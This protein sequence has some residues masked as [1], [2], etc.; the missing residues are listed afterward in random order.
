[1]YSVKLAVVRTRLILAASVLSMFA[2]PGL[3][4]QAVAD[5]KNNNAS[6][7]K[8]DVVVLSPFVVSGEDDNGY[9]ATSTLAGTRVRTDLRDVPSATTA[10]T[11]QFMKDIGATNQQDLL[12]YTT[13][14]EVGGVRGNF[15]GMG[16][17][18]GISEHSNLLNPSQNTRVRGL[19]TAQNTRDYFN[20]DIPWDSYIV[21][22]VDLQRGPNSVLFGIGSPAGIVNSS[23]NTAKFNDSVKIE[24]RVGSYNSLRETFDYNKVLLKNEL[25]FRVVALDDD[26]QYRQDPAFNHDKRIFGALRYEPKLF[27]DSAHTSIRANFESGTIDANRPRDLVPTDKITPYFSGEGKNNYDPYKAWNPP[28]IGASSAGW[29]AVTGATGTDNTMWN[30]WA[31]VYMAR[32]G[33]SNPVFWYDA[34]SGAP[35]YVQTSNPTATYGINSSGVVNGQIG[36]FPFARQTSIAGYNEYAINM[37]KANPNVFLGAQKNYYKDK[38]LTDPS[39][40]DFYNKLIDGPNK[41]EWQRWNAYNLALDQTFLDNKLGFEFV[42]DHQDS[43]N[44]QEGLL[45][46]DTPFIGVDINSYEMVLPSVLGNG[47]V[48][49]PNVDRAYIG[50]SNHYGNNRSHTIRDNYR[51]TAFAEIN[52]EDYLGKNFLARLLGKN[53]IT[54]LASRETTSTDTRNYV[55][56]ATDA[57]FAIDQGSTISPKISDGARQIDWIA[58]LSGNLS[59]RT[60][61]SGAGISNLSAV[62]SPQSTSVAIY[63]SHWKASL[64]PGSAGYVDPS[65]VWTDPNTGKPSTQSENPANY[66]GWTSKQVNVLS[67]ANG[68]IDQLYTDAS[69]QKKTIDSTGFTWQGSW[70]DDM[71]VPSFSWRRDKQKLQSADAPRDPVTAV[72]SMNYGITDPGTISVGDTKSYGVVLHLPKDIKKNLPAGMDVSLTYFH[73]D[74]T[75]PD[76]RYG[77]TGQ[78]L[79]PKSGKT[80]DYGIVISALDD[81]V[82]LK[83]N[84]FKTAGKNFDL[85]GDP[86]T[87]TLGANTYYLLDLQSWGTASAAIDTLGMQGKLASNG[88]EW[89]WDWA[90]IDNGWDGKYNDPKGADFLNAAS[91]AKEKAAVAAW[92]ATMPSQQFFDNYGL[93]VNVAK[94]KAG[95]TAGAVPTLIGNYS[96]GAIQPA[97]AGKINGLYPVG[98]VDTLSEGYEFEFNAR[99]TKNWN[100]TFNA[101]KTNAY[102]SNLGAELSTFIVQ[103]QTRFAGPAGDLRLWWGGDNTIRQYWVQ[104]IWAAYQFQLESDGAAAPELRPWHFNLVTNYNFDRGLLKGTNVG[105]GYRWDSKLVLGYGLTNTLTNGVITDTFMDVNKPIYGT[106]ERHFDLWTGYGHKLSRKINWRAQLNLRNVGEKA[107]LVPV[108]AEPDG[109]PAAQRISEGMTWQLSNTFEF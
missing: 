35:Q 99:P 109:S 28:P 80:D 76:I 62:L 26:A 103:Q 89:Y 64:T 108:S 84:K 57:Q 73:G 65:A 100:L 29:G 101:S 97:G 68:N 51:F 90:L 6:T 106:P 40:F 37:N 46:G 2:G 102:R 21:G 17:Q 71:I 72:A 38:S 91:T 12:V 104:N 63:D 61:A 9:Q 34:N 66:I 22:R 88:L 7:D 16:N 50:G 43:S 83:I 75:S 74:N 41:K 87:S 55:L 86:S 47:A 32:L 78:S 19:D 45:N 30:P 15:G 79:A 44:G 39:I 10:I 92:I 98:T 31:S 1:M 11:A 54:G 82:S 27:S 93:P 23:I 14:T 48:A 33:S 18:N 85:S 53:T 5:A 69:K 60:S 25:S 77:F 59:G 52:A 42:V 105:M 36:G 8:G 67:V 81:K 49:N 3:R 96:V 107:H 70:F 94:M 24:A 58:Y 56:Y 13:N 4:A 20:T 95:D